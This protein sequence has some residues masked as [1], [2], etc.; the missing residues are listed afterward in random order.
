MIRTSRGKN[1][2]VKVTFVLPDGE[3]HGRVSVVGDFNGWRPGS[4]ELRKRTNG[5]R[6]T[7]VEVA[8]GTTLRFRYLATDGLWFDD[9]HAHQHDEHGSVFTA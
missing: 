3:P 2:A 6:S 4:H 9:P 8:Q 7:S 5:T 1:E